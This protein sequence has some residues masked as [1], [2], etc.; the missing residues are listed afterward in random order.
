MVKRYYLSIVHSIQMMMW[1]SGIADEKEFR[2]FQ[3]L[4]E[5]VE[6]VNILL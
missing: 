2:G 4:L 6:K 1:V 5:K 3:G